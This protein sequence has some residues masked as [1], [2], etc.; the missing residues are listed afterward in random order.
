[1]PPR[2]IPLNL[3]H[4]KYKRA[5]PPQLVF[6]YGE[7]REMAM[8]METL[9]MTGRAGCTLRGTELAARYQG[10]TD[11]VGRCQVDDPSACVET[12]M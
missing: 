3:H 11:K 10:S 4:T 12:K 7:T 2:P 6:T 5:L 9:D 1:M 8:G